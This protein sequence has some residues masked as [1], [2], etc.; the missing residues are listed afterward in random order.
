M[1]RHCGH[2][3][4]G[5]HN[6]RT[7]EHLTGSLQRQLENNQ[8]R[9]AEGYHQKGSVD[10]LRL[11]RRIANAAATLAMR[12][13]TNPVTGAAAVKKTRKQRA[14]SYCNSTEHDRRRCGAIIKDKRV[15][16]EATR[17]ARS[18][19][20][21]R[22]EELSAGIGTMYVTRTGYYDSDHNWQYGPRPLIIVGA[23]VDDYTFNSSYFT[24]EAVPAQKLM[25]SNRH[26]HTQTVSLSSLESIQRRLMEAQE[27]EADRPDLEFSPS[28][29]LAFSAEW[30]AADNI[31][32][33][34]IDWFRKG[35]A[36][37]WTFASLE[38]EP[39]R[40]T[41]SNQVLVKAARTL[42]YL[43]AEEA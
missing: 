39:S 3:G 7:C 42:G 6:R 4:T 30:F 35:V 18:H 15:Y 28:V 8:R 11:I 13:G 26:Q 36:R 41:Y 14:C 2:C 38:Q 37:D 31:N 29:P 43:P 16:Q 5:G 34:Q 22:V 20:A 33:S 10:E 19:I 32:W 27:L 24:F 21:R 23:Y 40:L 9:L 12:T 25:D 17:I 1:A